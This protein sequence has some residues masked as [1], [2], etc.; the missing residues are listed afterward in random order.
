MTVSRVLLRCVSVFFLTALK[1]MN[2]DSPFSDEQKIKTMKANAVSSETSF[3]Q[4]AEEIRLFQQVINNAIVV[5][6]MTLADDLINAQN[7]VKTLND[8]IDE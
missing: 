2:H 5:G 8:K 4:L 1:L 7:K 3:S 6:G